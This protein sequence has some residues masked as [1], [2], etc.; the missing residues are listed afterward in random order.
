M[1]TTILCLFIPAIIMTVIEVMGERRKP[2][3]PVR[4]S[5]S[6]TCGK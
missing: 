6:H 5:R 4:P 2:V 3:R 1:L